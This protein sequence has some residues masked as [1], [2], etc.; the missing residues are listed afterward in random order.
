MRLE[1]IGDDDEELGFGAW[2]EYSLREERCG[3]M[4]VRVDGEEEKRARV[5]FWFLLGLLWAGLRK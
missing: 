1:G 3:C 4:V 5:G 2:L